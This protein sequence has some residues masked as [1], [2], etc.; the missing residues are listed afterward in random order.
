MGQNF[1]TGP[2][3]QYDLTFSFKMLLGKLT[4]SDILAFAEDI[5]WSYSSDGL[6][7]K[8][9]LWEEHKAKLLDVSSN[10]PAK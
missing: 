4:E 5:V 2:F 10:I 9:V 3:I 6:F 7:D 8:G 1:C